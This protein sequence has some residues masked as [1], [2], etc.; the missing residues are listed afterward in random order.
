VVKIVITK[1]NIINKVITRKKTK[2]I[3]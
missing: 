3:I 1:A 2:N